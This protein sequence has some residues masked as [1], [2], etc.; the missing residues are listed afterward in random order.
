MPRSEW[1]ILGVSLDACWTDAS[2]FFGG[3]E[4]FPSGCVSVTGVTALLRHGNIH[5]MPLRDAI[6]AT[7]FKCGFMK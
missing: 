7:C 5:N 6:L 2:L 4:I 1:I 3:R